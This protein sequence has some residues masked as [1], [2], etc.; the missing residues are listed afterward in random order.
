MEGA[1]INSWGGLGLGDGGWQT[2]MALAEIGNV[3]KD[4]QSL[5]QELGL[6]QRQVA[7]YQRQHQQTTATAV[8]TSERREKIQ[9]LFSLK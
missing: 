7:H 6:L 5:K 8:T 4:V 3:E 9:G 1:G 2:Q